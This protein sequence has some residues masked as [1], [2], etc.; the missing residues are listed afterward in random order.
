MQCIFRNVLEDLRLGRV[1][2]RSNECRRAIVFA[3][4]L[5]GAAAAS[6]ADAPAAGAATGACV[7]E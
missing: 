2:Q 3:M 5:A 1:H 7:S 6:G 4:Y